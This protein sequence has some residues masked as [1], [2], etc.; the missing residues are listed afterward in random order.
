MAEVSTV[1]SLRERIAELVDPQCWEGWRAMHKFTLEHIAKDLRGV[2][3]TQ[4]RQV[5]AERADALHGAAKTRS[6]EVA[7]KI[8]ESVS[9]DVLLLLRDAPN[10]QDLATPEGLAVYREWHQ[11]LSQLNFEVLVAPGHSTSTEEEEI[12]PV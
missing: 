6:L 3:E 9:R 2:S 4:M 10:P 5:A 11:R 8:I 7:D 12:G 1:P